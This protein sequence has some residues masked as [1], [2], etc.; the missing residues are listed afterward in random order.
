MTLSLFIKF[1]QNYYKA[2]YTPLVKAE[3]VKYLSNWSE[4]KLELLKDC[5]LK[6]LP[7]YYKTCPDI[8]VIHKAEKNLNVLLAQQAI[9]TPVLIESTPVPEGQRNEVADLLKGLRHKLTNKNILKRNKNQR[10]VA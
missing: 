3:V 7:T 9:H 6:E 10:G 2:E 4:N 1:M 5:I 8:A